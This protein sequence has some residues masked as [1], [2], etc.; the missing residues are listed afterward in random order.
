MSNLILASSSKHR[1]ELLKNA[2]ISFV[3]ESANID[4]REV[5]KPILASGMSGAD[6]A[7]VLA[8]AKAADVSAR[9]PGAFV[10]GCDQTLTFEGELLHKPANMEE[11][12]RRLLALSGKTHELNSAICIVQDGEQLWNHLSVSRITF[13]ELDPGFVGRHV[14]SVGEGLLGSV[15][16][17][18][19][20][21][22]GIQLFDKMEGDF[23]S[24]VGLPLL[25]LLKELQKLG[26][27]ENQ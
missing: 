2:G 24:I 17:Y 20:E 22:P 26:L 27:L 18:Q 3:S 11:V 5:E 8:L 15:G 12:R 16:A 21:G 6:V 10:I 19:V 25:P 1:S 4:E 9:N 14:A 23:F 13:R 7:E